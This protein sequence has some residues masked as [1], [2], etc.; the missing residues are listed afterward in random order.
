MVITPDKLFLS[1]SK[2]AIEH[3]ASLFHNWTNGYSLE[4]PP[5]KQGSFRGK[6]LIEVKFPN[7]YV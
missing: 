4:G 7:C 5:R 2:N 1:Q 6:N 3:Y